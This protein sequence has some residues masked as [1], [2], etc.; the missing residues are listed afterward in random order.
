MP[1]VRS[2]QADRDEATPRRVRLIDPRPI[3]VLKADPGLGDGLDPERFAA[4]QEEVVAAS[5]ALEPSAESAAWGSERPGL[6]ASLLVIKGLLIRQ[7]AID[8]RQCSEL[9]GPGDVIRPWDG[10]PMGLPVDES[11][12]WRVVRPT[13][14]AF[15][16]RRFLSSASPWP[17]VLAAVVT[18]AVRRAQSLAAH[19][20]IS[21]MPR[22]DER[23]S[24]LFWHLAARWGRVTP[25]GVRVELPLTHELLAELVGAQ[26]PTVTSA[27]ARLAERDALL[28]EHVG[29]WL[30]AAPGRTEHG[31]NGSSRR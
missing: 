11:L 1:T 26:R 29:S 4:A 27:L 10:D 28:R 9:L 18:R 19:M 7:L 23:L 17:E 16:D 2:A 6:E 3:R 13:R 20:T 25:E 24:L 14:V 15:L 12:L 8:G 5:A 22:V 30:L 31:H 21:S